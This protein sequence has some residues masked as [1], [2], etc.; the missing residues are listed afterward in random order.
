MARGIRLLRRR[1]GEGFPR[2]AWLRRHRLLDA[3]VLG[4]HFHRR[5]LAAQGRAFQT[6]E[7]ITGFDRLLRQYLD[8][9]LKKLG[10]AIAVSD[11]ASR[12]LDAGVDVAFEI[13]L[14]YDRE[15][16]RPDLRLTFPANETAFAEVSL[17]GDSQA[18]EA[19]AAVSSE[20][21][22]ALFFGPGAMKGCV[23]IERTLSPAHTAHLIEEI[24]A[25]RSEAVATGEFRSLERPGTIWVGLSGSKG[26]P[27]L[28]RW[29]AARGLQVNSGVGPGTVEDVAL[30]VASKIQHEQR[31][32]SRQHPGIV[33][34]P[35][36]K[37]TF[38]PLEMFERL[39]VIEEEVFKH[40][41]VAMAI[42]QWT[43]RRLEDVLPPDALPSS[44]ASELL[45][46]D[47]PRQQLIVW[48]RFAAQKISDSARELVR[49]A[50]ALKPELERGDW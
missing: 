43:A 26:M 46:V 45:T 50:L 35:V 47:S 31:Q 23:H 25:L 10:E 17:L 32:L 20:I 18:W 39:A 38:S 11:I 28:G 21:T 41:H 5:S 15:A 9:D 48:N 2:E 40:P 19:A 13:P 12:L 22:A 42:V 1:L 36:T 37:V 6:L 4:G 14:S 29:A 44:A 8:P 24:R 33:F 34:I 16:S 30:R 3:F 27:E 7:G 49:R